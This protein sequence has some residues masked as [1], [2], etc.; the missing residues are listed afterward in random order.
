[1]TTLIIDVSNMHKGQNA[2]DGNNGGR[3]A[4]S[5]HI[6]FKA[7][8]STGCSFCCFVLTIYP[9]LKGMTERDNA[10]FKTHLQN[11]HGLKEE[12]QP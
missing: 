7:Q 2:A 4:Y 5:A 11:T 3:K 1:M 8:S 6:H 9:T 10:T 12:I